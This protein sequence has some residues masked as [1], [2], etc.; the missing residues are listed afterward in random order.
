M[1]VFSIFWNI[2]DKKDKLSFFIII[3]FSILQAILEMIGIAAAIPFISF[4][5]KPETILNIEIIKNNFEVNSLELNFNFVLFFCFLFFFIFLIKNILIIYTNKI[6]YKFIFNLRSKLYSTLINK[7]LSQEFLFFVRKGATEIFNITFNELQNFTMN[8]SRPIIT[9]ISELMVSFGILILIFITGNHESLLLIIPIIFLVGLVLKII[10]RSIKNWSIARIANT[11]KIIDTNSNLVNGI[12]EI[13]IYGK[14]KEIISKLNSAL[15]SLKK[16]DIKNNL[17]TTLPRALLEQAVILIFISIILF[18][19]YQ[20]KSNDG[21]IITLGF[22][23]AAAYRLVPSINKIFVAYQQIKFGKPSIPKVLEFYNLEQKND[24]TQTI[25]KSDFKFAE[26]IILKEI[27]FEYRKRNTIIENLNLEIN[28][29]EIIGIF[30]NS[31]VGKSSLINILTSLLKSKTGKIFVDGIEVKT[32][33]DFKRYKNLFSIS[34]QDTF[35]IE[36][37]IRDNIT[38]GSKNKIE[39]ENLEFA[40]DFS[41]IKKITNNLPEGLETNIGSNLKQ[42]SS[43]QKQR[44]S[45]SRS[46]YSNR[47]ILIFDEATNALDEESE[48][49]IFKNIRKLKSN[50]TIIIITH[51]KKNLEICDKIYELKN[52]KLVKV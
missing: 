31:G 27:D 4:L 39:E 37:S 3:C 2:L 47:K 32:F 21:I 17:I 38:L 45:I 36:G 20:G 23:L 25:D 16:I 22:Y 51:N 34:S 5:L 14:T 46:I 7:V 49:Q 11:E 44:I 43:G 40:I 19:Y 52:K 26:K 6:T 29:N 12:K 24:N 30:G 9:L 41:Q 28:K 13:L 42:L 50:K 18:M 35:L 15:F 48:E 10:N 8:I 33:T 1:K